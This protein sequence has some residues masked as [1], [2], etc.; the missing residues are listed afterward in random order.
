[1][2]KLFL[3]TI[4]LCLLSFACCQLPYWQQQVNFSIDVSLND[5]EH[6]L[7]GFEKIEYLNNS[8]DTLRF[9][10]F[11][12]WPNAYKNDKTAYSDQALENGSTKFYF[13][14][15]ENR[16]YI[17]RLDFKV[18]NIT[19]ALEDHPLHI[20]ILKL[21]LPTALAPGEKINITTPFHVQLPFNFSR[22]GHEGQSYQVTQWY[23]KPA[24]YD[25]KGWHPMPYL[26]QGEFYSEFGNYDVR[27]SLPENYV[28]AATGELQ[29]KDELTWIKNRSSFTWEPL[30]EKVKTKTGQ[31]QTITQE[32]PVSSAKIKR[33]EFRQ[34]NVHDFAWFADK[35]FIVN[36]DTCQLSSGKIIDVYS[37][38][39]PS[40]KASWKNS[41]QFIKDAAR[42]RSEWVGEYPYNVISAVQGPQSFGGGMEYPTITIISPEAN[43]RLLE[44]T[45]VHEVS[46]NW[47]YGILASNERKHPWM[48]EGVNTYYDNRY[49][50]WKYG[51][52]GEIKIRNNNIPLKNAERILFESAAAG[53]KDQAVI[54]SGEGFTSMNYN[55]IAYYK[56][57]A[58]MELLEQKLG[59]EIL[60]KAM[61]EYYR[62]WKFKHPYP[63]DFKKI[64]ETVSSQ[65]LTYEFTLLEKKGTL[66]GMERKGWKTVFPVSPDS[67]VAYINNPSKDWL[68]LST[69]AGLNSYDKLMIGGLITNYKLPASPFQFIFTPMYSTGAKKINGIGKLNYSFFPEKNFRKIDLF[70]NASSFSSNEFLKADGKKS[71]AGFKKLVSGFRLTMQEKNPRSSISRYIQWKSYFINEGSFRIS[72][73]SVFTGTD[74]V[75]QQQV[76]IS[77]ENR[78]LQQLKFVLRNDRVLYPYSAELNIEQG[79]DFLRTGFT[80]NYFFNYPK[81]GGLDVRLFAGK[82]FYPGS[83]TFTKQFTTDRYHLN[84]TGANGYEDYTYSDYFIG[85]NK[86]QG[87]SSQQ[88]MNR[89]GGF[90]VRTDLYSD[91]VG[92]TDDWL[93]A[94]N[95]STTIPEGIN[96][97]S[98]LPVKIPL[99]LFADIGTYAEA[100]KRDANLDRFIFDAGLQLSFFSN[101]INIYLPLVYSSV[102]KEYI[103]SVLEKKGRFFKTISF[104]IDISNFT[105]KKISRELDF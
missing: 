59:K 66:P 48:D 71:I 53:K 61:Q 19:A 44:F 46:H 74:T 38:Y 39:T 88:I 68:L 105:L 58:W 42:T 94:L 32:F 18:N 11:H 50:E 15:K 100:W 26:D 70:V 24:V 9:I 82:F 84:M 8:P 30:K 7:E 83:K 91:K 1:M 57:G 90:K 79:K 34:N 85:R 21:I 72:Y 97:L 16:G 93:A 13:T 14:G 41:I 5:K 54:T 4:S 95:F 75:I 80:G 52:E 40:Q 10:W 99:K 77:N 62:Q 3:F 63:E 64:V 76:S 81:G 2:K 73:D 86:F 98:V 87:A 101:T 49:S 36:Y 31:V 29:N 51:N 65:D 17:N 56:T 22:G 92:K 23:P 60:D 6:T 47:F 20:D 96:P 25:H 37:Y 69:I 12:L 78:T 103:Q 33:L 67:Y 45:I 27:I 104:N 102:Y 89:D 55:L 43:E 28:V 35:R